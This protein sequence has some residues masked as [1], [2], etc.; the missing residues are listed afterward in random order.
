MGLIEAIV[1]GLVQG[2]TEFLPISSTA[3]LRIVP[4][5][6][7]WPDPGAAFT[8][9]IQLGTLLAVLI[10]FRNDLYRVLS[11]MIRREPVESKIGLG[12]AIGTLPVVILGLAGKDFIEGSLRSLYVIAGSLI[13]MGLV[14]LLAE[15]AGK[16]T[17]SFED[18]TTK[19]GVI[20]GLWQA[21]ALIPGAS[22]SGSTISGALFCGLDRPTAARF[23]FLLSVPS[24]FAA[25]VY[26]AYKYR[27]DLFGQALVPTLVS[28][29]V[30][31]V[32]GYGSIAFLIAFLQK[33]STTVF[34]IYRCV[35]G[36]AILALLLSGVLDPIAGIV[37]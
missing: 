8:A 30:S 33:S 29:L 17:R 10:F 19:D 20:I 4:S 5:L 3:H 27:H 12:I 34:V 11:G 9:T 35:L 28:T 25:G 31:F 36:V 26:E 21:V 16:R 15:R 14:L 7:G 22:R 13:I 37:K 6:L 2:L 18:L 1:L 32:V 24:I 23:S